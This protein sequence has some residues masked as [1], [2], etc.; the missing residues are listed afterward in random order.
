MAD[1]SEVVVDWFACCD[2]KSRTAKFVKRG[3]DSIKKLRDLKEDQ[4]RKVESDRLMKVKFR[5]LQDR[6]STGEEL[7][8]EVSV[9]MYVCECDINTLYMW[10]GV[11]RDARAWGGMPVYCSPMSCL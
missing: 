5:I 11:C 3:I 4:F 2:C 1:S 6:T 8:Q 9:S 10:S 7:S